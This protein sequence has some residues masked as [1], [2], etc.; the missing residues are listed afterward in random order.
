MLKWLLKSLLI[1]AVFVPFATALPVASLWRRRT[2]EG[3]QFF[4]WCG[5]WSACFWSLILIGV[6]GIAFLAR[7]RSRTGVA[8]RARRLRAVLHE[9]HRRDVQRVVPFLRLRI[10]VHIPDAALTISHTTLADC[11]LRPRGSGFCGAQPV[12]KII[13]FRK[14]RRLTPGIVGEL[15]RI[16]SSCV[17]DQAGK[18]PLLVSV[19]SLTWE[20]NQ[21]AN[22]GNEEDN[23]FAGHDPMCAARPISDHDIERSLGRTASRRFDERGA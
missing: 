12:A 18:C 17:H 19:S 9:V 14:P 4:F 13:P 7:A 11:H 6:C 15:L 21:A 5:P 2:P 16:H 22:I 1:A 8:C 10:R 20:L 3:G 23:A